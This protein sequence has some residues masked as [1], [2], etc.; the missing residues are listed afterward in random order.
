MAIINTQ[1]RVGPEW[2]GRKEI[3]VADTYFE[4]L[5]QSLSACPEVAAIALGGSRATGT[6]DSQSDYDV[7]VY[8]DQS[9][10]LVQR[11][12][13]AAANC[14]YAELNN[15]YWEMEDDCILKN[16]I[17]IDLVYRSLADTD[18]SLTRTLID[19]QPNNSYT[20]C[21]WSNVLHSQILFDRHGTY[22]ML[23]N[24]YS[25]PYPEELRTRIIER[26]RNLLKG[27]LPSYYDQVKKAVE[28]QDLVS[29]NH[30]TAEFLASYFDILLAYNRLP[31]PG[32]KRLM[33]FVQRECA[34]V[35]INF[36][37]DLEAVIRGIGTAD[38]RL[39]AGLDQLIDHLDLLLGN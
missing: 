39:I 1:Y 7:Y 23:K 21:L 6:S 11:Q 19:C 3:D 26:S 10:S 12:E 14:R 30:R 29:I 5:I 17:A 33:S 36:A 4:D 20:T 37:A 38:E 9:L 28:R 22:Q 2:T 18:A 35:P 27:K 32:E 31:H 25:L 16:G 34:Q 8:L 24:R 15:T 13:I